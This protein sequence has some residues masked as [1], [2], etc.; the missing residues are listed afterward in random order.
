[1]GFNILRLESGLDFE[2][3]SQTEEFGFTRNRQVL[4][5]W[6]KVGLLTSGM[7]TGPLKIQNQRMIRQTTFANCHY[8]SN[9]PETLIL[10]PLEKRTAIADNESEGV[11]FLSW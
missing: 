9:R 11:R 8:N 2:L 1:M 6:E 5:N 4:I 7:N 3:V 10:L